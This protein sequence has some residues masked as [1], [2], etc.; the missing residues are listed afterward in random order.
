MRP[1][2]SLSLPLTRFS[3]R[4]QQPYRTTQLVFPGAKSVHHDSSMRNNGFD[5]GG[6]FHNPATSSAAANTIC[7][8]IEHQVRFS[9]IARAAVETGSGPLASGHDKGLPNG[10]C[11]QLSTRQE[12]EVGSSEQL[13]LETF[14]FWQR[15]CSQLF[16]GLGNP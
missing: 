3:T 16:A 12:P 7:Q 11:K 6:Y 13:S 8:A 14:N 15:L 5:D 1:R 2:T 9:R 4:A 10:G